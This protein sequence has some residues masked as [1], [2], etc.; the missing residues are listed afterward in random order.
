MALS[1]TRFDPFARM[2]RADPFREFDDFFSDMRMP[3]L[4]RADVAPR[5]RIDVT[6]TDQGYKVMADL[7]GVKKDDIKVNIDGAQV[8]ISAAT[9]SRNEQE[10]AGAI[11]TERAWGQYY[12]S[13]TLPQAVD[14]SQARAE[15][16]DG[17]LELN[18]PKKAGGSAKPLA[19]Q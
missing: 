6:E 18:L 7:P 12:R 10:A 1:L 8:S 4:L 14:D 17:V 15:F 3:S 5:V 2:L 19:I 9:E 16:H 13:F 11:C